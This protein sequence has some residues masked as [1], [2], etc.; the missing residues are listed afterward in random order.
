VGHVLGFVEGDPAQADGE[1]STW[2]G[3]YRAITATWSNES[4]PAVNSAITVGSSPWRRATDTTWRAWD[5]ESPARN[6]SQCS[7]ERIPAIAHDSSAKAAAV[8]ATSRA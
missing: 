3:A 5:G 7:G 1:A 8:I 4:W 6:V 2:A